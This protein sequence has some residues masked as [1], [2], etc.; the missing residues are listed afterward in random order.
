MPCGTVV[1]KRTDLIDYTGKVVISEEEEMKKMQSEI[2][3]VKKNSGKN[4]QLTL[5]QVIIIV[6][7]YLI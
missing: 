1:G 6:I 2:D 7:A 5:A 4:G 3:K